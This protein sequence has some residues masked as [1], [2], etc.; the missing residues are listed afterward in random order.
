MSNQGNVQASVR[1]RSG[2]TAELDWNGDFHYLWDQEGIADG[3][4]NERMLTWINTELGETYTNLPGAM[5]AYAESL[6]FYN[7]SSMTAIGAGGP[8]AVIWED[9]TG[10]VSAPGDG[11]LL[12]SGATSPSGALSNTQLDPDDFEVRWLVSS[13]AASDSVW[14]GL[15]TTVPDYDPAD[16]DFRIAISSTS[17]GRLFYGTQENNTTIIGD[18]DVSI[19]PFYLRMRSSGDDIVFERSANQASWTHLVTITGGLTGASALY[20]YSFNTGAGSGDTI[21]VWAGEQG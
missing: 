13:V 5:Q 21:Q 10:D 1:T 20:L 16:E 6:G 12:W 19:Y 14:V 8:P 15:S 17:L 2:V 11:V 7:W 3:T 4:F 9:L 18:I